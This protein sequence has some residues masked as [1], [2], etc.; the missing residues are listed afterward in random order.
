RNAPG[1]G[2]L[3]FDR[4]R[5]AHQIF[6]DHYREHCVDFTR[7]YPGAFELLESLRSRRVKMAVV[8]NK[9]QEFTDL[10]LKRLD[11]WDFFECAGARSHGEPQTPSRALV[12][13]PGKNGRPAFRRGHDRGL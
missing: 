5:E 12:Q 9:P 6:K 1:N 10:I 13:S 4:L 11:L 7:P 3:N 2:P 8:S